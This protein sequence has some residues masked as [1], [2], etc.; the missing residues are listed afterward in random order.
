[1]IDLAE[2]FCHPC[3][4][5]LFNI[6]P[7]AR[8]WSMIMDMIPPTMLYNIHVVRFQYMYLQNCSSYGFLFVTVATGIFIG[9]LPH[10]EKFFMKFLGTGTFRNKNP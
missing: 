8:I 4:N 10:H 6:Y 9:T 5:F 1:M 7:Y 3:L 2:F